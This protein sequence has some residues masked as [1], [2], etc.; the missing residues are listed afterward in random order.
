MFAVWLLL[1]LVTACAKLQQKAINQSTGLLCLRAAAH[2]LEWLAPIA[3]WS[4]RANLLSSSSP[5]GD[6]E[7]EL[8][9]Q[10]F[11]R[12]LLVEVVVS[13]VE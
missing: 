1:V 6:E 10:R 3:L 13:Q 12:L 5:S 4:G 7:G 2:L 11:S 9:R 8:V